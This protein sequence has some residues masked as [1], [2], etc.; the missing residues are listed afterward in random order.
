MNAENY[1]IFV[2]DDDQEVCTALRWLYESV[3]FNVKTYNSGQ[4]F[5]EH[6]DPSKQGCIIVDVR[7]PMMSGLELL[8]HI[9]M[10]KNQIPVIVITGYG[11]ISMA[12]RAMKLGAVDFIL[13]P[14]NDQ[15]LLETVQKCINH[16]SKVNTVEVSE[17][18]KLLSKRELQI[19]DLILEGKLNKEIAYELSI[20]ISTVEA[21]RAHIMQKMQA[22]TIAHL[23]KLYLQSQPVEMM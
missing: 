1:T 2:I 21:H 14:I 13:K 7:M 23:I 11:D 5:L 9:K 10:R 17:R 12:V 18:V 8:E 16:S 6:Y 22:K 19:I 4:A 15:S 20:S 3:N